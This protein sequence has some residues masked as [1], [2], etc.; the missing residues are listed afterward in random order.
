M[1]L[2]RIHPMPTPGTTGPSTL[3]ALAVMA[4]GPMLGLA[5][6]GGDGSDPEASG[7]S[8][9]AAG[10]DGESIHRVSVAIGSETFLVE[11]PPSGPR[12][13]FGTKEI[14]LTI[15]AS[16]DPAE[17]MGEGIL[18]NLMTKCVEEGELKLVPNTVAS[19]TKDPSEAEIIL[20]IQGNQEF[21]ELR[22]RSGTVTL[23]EVKSRVDGKRFSVTE[24]KGTFDGQFLASTGV[25]HAVKGEF[26]YEK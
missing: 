19:W 9:L 24:I 6:C 2:Q 26:R 8:R 13:A 17:Y 14:N 23:E 20:W 25:T 10:E 16:Y 4:L 22:S 5:S 11:G 21:G 15:G 7:D 18:L 1:P 3:L 12:I